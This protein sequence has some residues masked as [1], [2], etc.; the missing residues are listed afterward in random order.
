LSRI[1]HILTSRAWPIVATLVILYGV[2]AW[3]GIREKSTTFDEMAHL[4]GGYSYWQTGD[5]RLNPENGILP[6]R[7]AALPLFMMDVRFPDQKQ[8]GWWDS[9]V[10]ALGYQFFYNSQNDLG[11]MLWWGRGM[12]VLL[13]MAL[14]GVVYVWS[15]RLFGPAGAMVSL[16]VCAFSPTLLAHGSLITSDMAA[17]LAFAASLGCLW[18]VLHRVSAITLIASAAL[19]GCLFVTKMSAVLML[20]TAL[21]LAGIRLAAGRPLVLSWRGTRL[22]RGRL[23]QL[24]VVACVAVFH[25]VAVI[26]VIWLFYGFHYA[27]FRQAQT[28]LDSMY[29]G[30][31]IQSLTEGSVLGPAVRLA[32]DYHL[33]PEPYLH[34][35]SYVAHMSGARVAFFNGEFGTRGWKL[36][37]PYCLMVKT[38]LAIFAILL[39]G[40]AAAAMRW[41]GRH[42]AAGRQST[43]IWGRVRR[44]LYRTAPLWVF[45][46]VYWSVAIFTHLNIGHRHILPTY[47][48]MFILCGA[49]G[50]W[51]Q[52]RYKFV[53][54]CV[55]LALAEL[56]V[57]SVAICPNYLAYFNQL[58]GGPRHG[59]RHLVDSS[60]DWGQDLPGL[61]RWLSQR[62][63]TDPEGKPIY[64]SYFGTGS[65]EYYGIDS[66]RLPGYMDWRKPIVHELRPGT[67]CISATML[68]CVY[69][70]PPGPWDTKHEQYYQDVRAAVAELSRKQKQDPA[71]HE[72]LLRDPAAGELRSQWNRLLSAFDQCRLARLCAFLRQREPDDSVGY[73]ILIYH[74]NADDLDRALNRSPAAW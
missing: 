59:Y 15:R 43:A 55:V 41:C 51:F 35:F 29:G 64:L 21:I 30:Y 70:S 61:K 11:R 26:F 22:I 62:Q 27:T 7:W 31:T 2:M 42:G 32:N 25:A 36:F 58:A 68:Q 65:P 19:M 20:P 48:M 24:A 57:E 67:Y 13:G 33:L 69:I 3:S 50:Y 60:L 46:A 44:G 18:I 73:S 37:F 49:A 14:A 52:R 1:A 45:L 28:Q 66:L 10:W 54:L 47:P 23:P 53:A 56:A 74:I 71:A 17:T 38:P 39:A 63:G 40:S 4:T 72:R 9:D 12:I 6:Q 16:L 5:Y 34:G 8:F